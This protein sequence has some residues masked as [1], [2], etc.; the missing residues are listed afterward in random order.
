VTIYVD[1][2]FTWP[3]KSGQWCHMATDGDLSEL[4]AMADKIGMQRR[5]F[6]NKPRHPHY[7][8]R[9]SKRVLAVRYGAIEVSGGELVRRCVM[10]KPAAPTPVAEQGGE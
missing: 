9:P 2:L 3:G 1:P 7:D 8:L 6:Q 10:Q 5:W 4:H